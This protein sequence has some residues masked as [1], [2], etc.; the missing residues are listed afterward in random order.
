MPAASALLVL[1]MLSVSFE[2][3]LLSLGCVC[4]R[5]KEWFFFLEPMHFGTLSG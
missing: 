4:V 3:P 1:L 5:E 2:G